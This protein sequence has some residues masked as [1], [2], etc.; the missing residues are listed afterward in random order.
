MF[1][2]HINPLI[3]KTQGGNLNHCGKV[4]SKTPKE[5]RNKIELVKLR[6]QLE[7]AVQCEDYEQAAKLRD[8]I[9]KLT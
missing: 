6:Q 4:P 9:N 7:A 5:A 8:K 3:S 2:E 1:G